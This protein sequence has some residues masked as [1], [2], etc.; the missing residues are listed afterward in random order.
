MPKSVLPK[1]LR[2]YAETPAEPAPTVVP[3]MQ[4]QIRL[5]N[6]PRRPAILSI[7]QDISDLEALALINAVLQITDSL[8]AQRS[9]SRIILPS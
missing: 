8:R 5:L 4:A 7:P 3:L 1:A 6:D 9:A 2:R